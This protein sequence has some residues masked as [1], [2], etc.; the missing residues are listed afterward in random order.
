MQVDPADLKGELTFANQA[1]SEWD[2]FWRRF[3]GAPDLRGK[4]LLDF[5]CNR[6]G[7]IQ[8][9]LRDGAAQAT[10][11]DINP[12]TTRWGREKLRKQWGERAQILCGDISTLSPGPVDIVMST[13]TMEH[14]SDIGG[15]LRALVAACRTGGELFIGFSPLWF[16]PYGNH[17]YPRSRIPWNHLLRGDDIV[18]DDLARHLDWRYDT[19]QEA[20]FNCATPDQF[21]AGLAG[22]DVEI[23]SARRNV[24]RSRMRTLISQ[25]ILALSVI[26]ALEKY[27]TVGFFWHLRRRPAQE[28]SSS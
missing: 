11:V 15:T 23:L 19:V 14:V 16:S 7:S 3:G 18:L 6:G 1:G 10:G 25:S 22:L 28:E 27:V 24:G 9:A 8:R 5:G 26:P 13:N 20:G 12:Y 2:D 17:G 4:T 21:R